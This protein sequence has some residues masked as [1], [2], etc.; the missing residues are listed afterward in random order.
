MYGEDSNS[1]ER[2]VSAKP[3]GGL[4]TKVKSRLQPSYGLPL[5]VLPA[6]LAASKKLSLSYTTIVEHLRVEC[7]A[8]R[9]YHFYMPHLLL[10]ICA[11]C[12][13]PAA[14]FYLRSFFNVNSQIRVFL[15][16]DAF[17]QRKEFS[18]RVLAL[19][20]FCQLLAGAVLAICE[21]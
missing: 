14:T 6:I 8:P 21:S 7:G 11:R 19:R 4:V 18:R 13:K 1:V 17:P 10:Y 16:I 3:S 20:E 12:E 2:I 15:F 5:C 9:D